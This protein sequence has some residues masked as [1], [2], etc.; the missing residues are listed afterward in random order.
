MAYSKQTWTDGDTTK[1]VSAAR[2]QHI[3]DGL[4]AVANG[5]SMPVVTSSVTRDAAGRVSA[6]T[7]ASGSYTV[8]YDAST[9]LA[10]SVSNGVVTRT[11]SRDASGLVT[12][13]A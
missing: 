5:G 1:P 8:A 10:S 7:D 11:I 13:V 4:D 3:E 12:G 6:F 9:G 2:M